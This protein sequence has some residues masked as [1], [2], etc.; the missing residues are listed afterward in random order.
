MAFQISP[1][2]NVSEIDLTGII[3][4]VSTSTGAMAGHFNWGPVGNRVLVDSESTL[5]A[6]FSIPNS[7]TASDFFTAANFLAYTN[8]LY[9]TRV[10]RSS[11]TSTLSTDPVVSRNAISNSSNTK[12]TIIKSDDDYNDNYSSGISDVGNWVAKYPGALGN[13]LRVSVCQSANAYESTLTGNVYFSNNSAT[14]TGVGT[15]FDNE[16]TVGDILVLGPE[17]VERKVGSISSNTSLTIQ[18]VYVGNTV[19][20][21]SQQ[22]NPTRKWEFH[23]FVS[24]APGSSAGA[25]IQGS[26]G[27]EMHVVVADEDGQISGIANTVLE[28]FPSVSKAYDAK[29]EIGNN[30]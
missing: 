4:A 30:I 5:A 10:V 9:V 16:V 29:D 20:I 23:N 21:A 13:S 8:S 27:D 1:G 3:P 11:N 12:N 14:V 26:S 18:S 2:V 24:V 7:N 15:V 22:N 19:A 6:T 17:K 28:V 25:L